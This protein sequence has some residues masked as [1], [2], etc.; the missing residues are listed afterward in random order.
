LAYS[1]TPAPPA[2]RCAWCEHQFDDAD[3]RLAG[4]TRCG[5]CGVATTSP[6]PSDAQ[7]GEAYADWYRPANGRFSGLGDKLLRRSRS[8]L[9]D[10]L[11]RV[12]PRGPV[13]D[14]GAGDGTLVRAFVR[15]GREAVGVDPYASAN[16]PHVRDVELE[17][18]DGN[19][20]AV[21]FWHSLEHLREPVRALRHAATLAAPG[22]VLVVAVPNAASLQART[23]GDRWLHLDVPRHLVH[24]SPPALV[25]AI[26]AAGF[27]V[28]RVSYLRGGQVVF[29][30]LHG[31]VGKFFPG[32]PDL[33]DAIRRSEARQ[34]AQSPL[35]RLY[36]LAAAVITLPAALVATGFEVAAR[37]G[38]TIYVEARR[39]PDQEPAATA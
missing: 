9:A 8:V 16:H 30:W 24:I 20:S 13:L 28:M 34:A 33:Y 7:L 5:R 15:H 17:E 38:G 18:M 37:A 21:I 32:H 2:S 35:F 31:L 26:E 23:F 1:R 12:L 29:G 11:H 4:R 10:R 27:R 36:T 6:W 25:S 19:W 39:E 22:G 3:D 14:V